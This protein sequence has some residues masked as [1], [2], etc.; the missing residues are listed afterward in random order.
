MCHRVKG[1]TQLSA[2]QQPSVLPGVEERWKFIEP[3]LKKAPFLK[4]VPMIGSLGCPYTCSFCIDSTVPY[5]TLNFETMKKDLSFLRTKFKR[6]LIAWHDPNF[7]IRF[8]E[9]MGAIASAAPPKSFRFIAESSLSILTESHLKS[10]KQNGFEAMLPGIESW[11]DL[12]NKSKTSHIAGEEKV[13]RISEHVNMMFQYIPY[14]Q[15]NFVLGMD[16]DA[17]EEPFE[18]TKRFVDKSPAAFPGY[19]LLSAFG[20]A[21][22][23]NL[24]YQRENRVLGF[25]FHFLNNHLAMNIKPKNYEWLDFYDKV[26][27]LTAYTF[28]ARAIYRRF[29]ATKD[30]TNRW[31]N[32]MRAISNEGHGRLRFYRQVRKNLAEDRHFR[33]YFEGASTK[34]PDFYTNIIKK[35]LGT[36]WEWLPQGAIEHD[37]NAY[38]N[39]QPKKNIAATLI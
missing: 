35:S 5:Q 20:E 23:L 10:M 32:F 31:M 11:Y 30:Y 37:P 3:T 18:L 8:E 2:K 38:L 29:R 14:I 25:P 19:S 15:T 9:N 27:D 39:K 22:P 36:W 12:G 28:S 33:D 7:G 4:I 17:G 16:S 34:L 6:P 24:Q 13:N 21:A 1:G 26:I